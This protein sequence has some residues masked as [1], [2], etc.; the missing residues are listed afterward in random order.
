MNK[1]YRIPDRLIQKYSVIGPR[2]TSYPTVPVWGPVDLD[3]QKLWYHELANS[4]RPLSLYFHIP[5]CRERC[6]YCGCNTMITQN[7]GKAT[8][9]VSYLLAE[10][11]K[12]ASYGLSHKKLRQLHFGGGTPTFLLD[13]EFKQIIGK[14]REHFTFEEGAE[15]AIEVD[16]CSTHDGQLEMLA[17]LGFNRLSLGLQDF[18]PQVQQAVNRIQSLEITKA[19]IDLARKLGFKGVNLDLMYGLPH[20][21]L[22]SMKET[23]EQVI[24][25]KPDRLALYNFAYLPEQLPHQKL[26]HLEDLPNEKVKLEIFFAA[27][28]A[29]GRAGY[30]YI[31]MDHFAKSDDELSKAQHSRRLYR[32]FM[33][34]SPKSGV[35]LVGIG[36]TSIGE[37]EHYFL[38]NE[39]TLSQYQKQIEA[40]G[41]AG[42]KGIRLSLDDRIRK[43]TILRLMCHFYLSFVEFEAAF[44]QDFK[45]YFAGELAGI[46]DMVEEGLLKVEADHI[47]VLDWGKLLVRNICMRFDAYLKGDQAPKVKFSKTL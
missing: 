47:Q 28:E 44:H 5:F 23:F 25:L 6:S 21:S 38:Q 26:I 30:E 10:L 9:Y 45:T 2:Y 8:D 20:Q 43:W 17:E 24:S 1:I 19:H 39:K 35:D 41:L 46:E 15:L 22:E 31:G 3:T 4:D 36:I 42:A 34:Y 33:G 32:N 27:I 13:A 7:Q 12:L 16:P 37:T 14:V 11:D 29:F 40:E 18:N